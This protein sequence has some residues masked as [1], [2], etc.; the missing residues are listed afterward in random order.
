[1][2]GVDVLDARRKLA[3]SSKASHGVERKGSKAWI[4]RKKEQMTRQG[5]VVKAN[6]KYTG[7]KRRT[8]F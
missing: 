2:D 1:M 7:R 6:S 5:K 4:L 3:E 8:A